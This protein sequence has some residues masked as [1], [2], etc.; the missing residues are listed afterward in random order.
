MGIQWANPNAKCFSK[1]KSHAFWL[2]GEAGVPGENPHM[3]RKSMQ[4]PWKRLQARIEPKTFLLHSSSS[5]NLTVMILD[6][7]EARVTRK[8]PSYPQ[9][10]HELFLLGS[11]PNTFLLKDKSSKDWFI[12]WN[13]FNREKNQF[14]SKFKWFFLFPFNLNG[15]HVPECWKWSNKQATVNFVKVCFLHGF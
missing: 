5:A 2:W 4:T 13:Q 1:S 10:E 15:S 11:K 6:W 8:E 3:Q 14:E 12:S 7:D 9:G